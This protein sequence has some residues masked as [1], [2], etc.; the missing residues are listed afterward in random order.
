MIAAGLQ[1]AERAFLPIGAVA[2]VPLHGHLVH[3]LRSYRPGHAGCNLIRLGLLQ[4]LADRAM[5][6]IVLDVASMGGELDGCLDLAEMIM[7]ARAQKPIWSICADHALGP[8]YVI[9][10]AATRVTVPRT[11]LLGEVGDMAMLVD[12]SGALRKAGLKVHVVAS[13]A[14]KGKQLRAESGGVT[15]KDLRAAQRQVDRLGSLL[16]REVARFRGV[17][18]GLIQT[19]QGGRVMGQRAVAAGLADAVMAPADAFAAL[20]SHLSVRQ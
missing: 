6:A 17:R 18:P 12:Q 8:A 2:V 14:E 11:G 4:A 16:T 5:K 10:A 9:A 7:R 15:R 20:G 13:G 3:V 1:A 19:L